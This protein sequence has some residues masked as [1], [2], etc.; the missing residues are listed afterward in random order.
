MSSSKRKIIGAL[1]AVRD[2]LVTQHTLLDDIKVLLVSLRDDHTEFRQH[3]LQE[4][5][6]HGSRLRALGKRVNEITVPGG[7]PHKP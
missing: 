2:E 5:D 4:I 1:E 3:V 7:G 6:D